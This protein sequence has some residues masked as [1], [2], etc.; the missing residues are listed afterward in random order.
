MPTP[1]GIAPPIPPNFLGDQVILANEGWND[2]VGDM[3]GIP[4]AM[5]QDISNLVS[6]GGGVGGTPTFTLPPADEFTLDN[7]IDGFQA[8]NDRFTY[9]VSASASD[10]YAVLLPTADIANAMVTTLPSYSLNLFLDGIQQFADGDPNGLINA[11]GN[12]IVASTGLITLA[13]GLEALSV[14]LAVGSIA[15]NFTGG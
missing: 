8:A 15:D 10:A 4:P 12:P 11:V 6:G 2:F 9:A 3:S 1:F 5:S 14:I 7:F 13:G